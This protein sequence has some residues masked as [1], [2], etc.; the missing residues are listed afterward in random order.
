VAHDK[1]RELLGHPEEGN[2]Q[3]SPGREPS[4]G[5]TTSEN[6]VSDDMNHH[7]RGASN[8]S[9]PV[10]TSGYPNIS[11]IMQEPLFDYS[12][13]HTFVFDDDIV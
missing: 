13:P 5:S 11:D 8:F 12:T 1:L 3:P 6:V 2:Q 9:I 10:I 7:E 4:E